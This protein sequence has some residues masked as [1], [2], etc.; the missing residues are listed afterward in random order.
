VCGGKDADELHR[1]HLT[2]FDDHPLA[3]DC[4]T[5]ICLSCGMGFNRETPPAE[6]YIRY[7]SELSKY[8]VST[9]ATTPLPRL[10][11][12]AEMLARLLP[13]DAALLDAGCGSGG[14][15]AALKKEGFTHLA[16]L[17]PT[18][19]CV[20]IV[21]DELGLDARVGTLEASPFPPASFDAI[22]ST[23]VFEH[24]HDPGAAVD[25]IGALL[26]PEGLA[27]ILV[28]DASR[29]GEFMTSPFQD[30]NVEHINHFSLG[31]LAKLFEARGWEQ[32]AAGTGTFRFSPTWQSTLIWGLFRK[33]GTTRRPEGSEPALRAGLQDYFAKS[34]A[35]LTNH[36]AQLREDLEGDLEI[37]LWGA[38]H[39]TSVLLAHGALAAKR[40]RAVIDGNPNYRGRRL[41]G[42]PVGGPELR[43]DF[44]GPIVVATIREQ[45]SVLNRIREL[46]W[47]NRTVC[48][49]D[50]RGGQT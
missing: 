15:L 45:E 27:Y 21:R 17:D 48:L 30:V 5:A 50:R 19:E 2:L 33:E 31:A 36:E 39:A 29:Y 28:P 23:V 32:V 18:P 13:R 10:P 14:V 16:G 12:C 44:A 37:L 8:V 35:L 20:R 47:P 22:I 26:K 6:A 46:R 49:Q 25:R 3:H 11:E 1:L 42:A 9:S 43:G 7:Y 24:L 38:G 41:A 40:V 4:V 34:I